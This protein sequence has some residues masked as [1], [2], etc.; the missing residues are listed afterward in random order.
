MHYRYALRIDE[1][2]ID[3]NKVILYLYGNTV[4]RK[5][6]KIRNLSTKIETSLPIKSIFLKIIP[7]NDRS[8]S[9]NLLNG[10]ETGLKNR[11]IR[12][13]VPEVIELTFLY[14]S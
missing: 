10:A 14:Y 12:Y 3:G 6:L 11:K 13:A 5:K 4:R 1:F 7:K 8:K 9:I 2:P